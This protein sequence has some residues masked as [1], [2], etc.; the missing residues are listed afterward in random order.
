MFFVKIRDFTNTNA[1][2]MID[3]TGRMAQI[4]EEENMIDL[5]KRERLYD[6]IVRKKKLYGTICA[7][8]KL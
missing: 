7:C 3:R 8:F 1:S 5:F 2:L 6:V 4:K